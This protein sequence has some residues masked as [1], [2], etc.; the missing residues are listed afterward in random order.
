MQADAKS[1]KRI[2]FGIKFLLFYTFSSINVT[3]A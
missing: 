2:G 1:L 3:H